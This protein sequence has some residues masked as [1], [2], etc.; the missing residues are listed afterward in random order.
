MQTSSNIQP[1][2]SIGMPVFNCAGTVAQAICSILN[3]T[4][5]DWEL[6]II[7]DGSTDNTLEIAAS[8]DDPRISVTRGEENKGLPARLNECVSRARGKYFERMDQ[9]DIAYPGRLQHQLEFL[10]SHPEVDLAGG[11]VVV[12]RNDGTAFGAR[13]GPLTH[14]QICAHPWN[15]IPMAHPT[16][17]GKLEWFR[18]NPYRTDAPR[19]KFDTQDQDL[20][21]RT[22]QKS[23]F[24]IVPEIV[25]GY[26]E[27]SLSLSKILYARRDMCKTMVRVA[28]E[29]HM[30]TTAALG[31]VGL[32]AKALVDT[33]AI[34]T[35]LKYH[36]LPHRATAIRGEEEIE[37]RTVW[38][39]VRLTSDRLLADCKLLSNTPHSTPV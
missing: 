23:R 35:G 22:H 19:Q 18:R 15:S 14:E 38:E 25:L 16:W 17:M 30:F 24:A 2:V 8:F 21:L 13:R 28:R 10:Q 4:V 12:F 34:S 27:N 32:I 33:L 11:W 20:L 39:Q 37:W 31:I 9:D 1:I 36:I 6:L 26:R 5:E 29:Q 3:Q 7:D